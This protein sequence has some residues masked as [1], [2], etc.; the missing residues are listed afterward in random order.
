LIQANWKSHP[1]ETLQVSFYRISHR[2]S[3]HLKKGQI[4][5]RAYVANRVD[6]E[7]SEKIRDQS[8]IK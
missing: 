7:M 8:R 6:Y 3:D 1:E 2:L 5:P 4:S